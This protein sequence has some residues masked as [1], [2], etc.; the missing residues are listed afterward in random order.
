M[1]VPWDLNNINFG[2]EFLKFIKHITFKNDYYNK[3]EYIF[4][5]L[6]SNETISMDIKIS[7]LKII[8]KNKINVIQYDIVDKLL[9]INSGDKIILEFNKEENSLFNIDDYKNNVYISDIIKK[10]IINNKENILDYVLFNLE[11]SII[12]F[13]I[14][15]IMI[16]LLN[17]PKNYF[18]IYV[19]LFTGFNVVFSLK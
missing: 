3:I 5:T 19:L 9:N 6:L 16:Y 13:K 1:W 11:N 17:I 15:P 12:N 10:C 8:N 4:N 18:T 7:Y 14:N 2:L